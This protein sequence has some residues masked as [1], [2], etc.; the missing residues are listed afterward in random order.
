MTDVLR[1]EDLMMVVLKMRFIPGILKNGDSRRG[2]LTNAGSTTD[3]L[4]NVGSMRGVLKI[5]SSMKDVPR[6]EDSMIGHVWVSGEW[7]KNRSKIKDWTKDGLTNGER[8]TVVEKTVLSGERNLM[9]TVLTGA[10]IPRWR[11]GKNFFSL[12][13]LVERFCSFNLCNV[14]LVMYVIQ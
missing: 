13:R 4:T 3:E 5:G 10:N 6:K 8:M 11:E 12:L 2:A 14:N 7:R 9:K 1:N